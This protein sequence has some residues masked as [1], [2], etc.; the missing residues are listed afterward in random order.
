MQSVVCK[1]PDFN[2]ISL[3]IISLHDAKCSEGSYLLLSID[4]DSLGVFLSYSAYWRLGS[5]TV[6]K[7]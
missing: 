6:W 3:K 1:N 7:M 5:T 2:Y 4:S